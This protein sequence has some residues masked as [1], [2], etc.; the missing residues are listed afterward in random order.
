MDVQ[1]NFTSDFSKLFEGLTKIADGLKSIRDQSQT[2]NK[3][4]QASAQTA[5]I[6]QQ[7]V[8]A[9]YQAT[10]DVL[11]EFANAASQTT[12]VD[13]QIAAAQELEKSFDDAADSA[14]KLGDTQKKAG[15]DAKASAGAAA[16]AQGAA[17]IKLNEAK[18][19]ALEMVSALKGVTEEQ[20]LQL[21]EWIETSQSVDEVA[22]VI[23][24]MSDFLGKTTE[25]TKTLKQEIREAEK[26]AIDISREFGELSP[27]ALEAQAK[28]G[29]LK[30][31]FNDFRERF[32]SFSPDKKF[33]A[34]IGIASSI[35]GAFTAAQ[36]ALGLFGAESENVARSIQKVQSSL[37][38]LQGLQA[39][40]GGFQDSLKNVIALI[41]N[42]TGVTKTATAATAASTAANTTATGAAVAQTGAVNGLS[43]AWARLTAFLLANPFV[44]A[45][46]A[47][48]AITVAMIAFSNETEEAKVQVQDLSDA[49]LQLREDQGKVVNTRAEILTI[50]EKLI[51]QQQGDAK[52]AEEAIKRAQSLRKIQTDALIEQKFLREQ[53][54][55]DLEQQFQAQVSQGNLTEVQIEE[56]RVQLEKTVSQ[57]NRDIESYSSEVEKIIA[58]RE[59][60][61]LEIVQEFTERQSEEAKKRAEE[62]SRQLKLL[63][64]E[65]EALNKKLKDS[66]NTA[67]IE[68]TTDPRLRLQ[69]E[70]EAALASIQILQDEI[71]K[72]QKLLTGNGELTADQEKYFASL[73][74][75][76]NQN[77]AEGIAK[78]E[79]EIL[80]IKLDALE[81]GR[82]REIAEFDLSAKERIE[83]MRKLGVDEIAIQTIINNQRIELEKKLREELLKSQEETAIL[84]A[85]LTPALTGENEV[86]RE[87]RVQLQIIEIKKEF[88][89]KRLADLSELNVAESDSQVLA[90]RKLIQD[91][92]KET[93]SILDKNKNKQFDLLDLL[94]INFDSDEAKQK[95]KQ[96]INDTF[97]L[98][99]EG[100]Q[101][102][103]DSQ[104]QLLEADKAANDAYIQ[105]LDDRID[106]TQ[107]ALDQEYQLQA[108]GLANNVDLKKKE[109]AQLQAEKQKALEKDKA[110]A[111]EQA[112]LQ[113]QQAVIDSLSQASSMAVTIANVFKAESGK[114]IVGVIAAA[115]AALG[116]VGLF[117]SLKA[118]FNDASKQQ[119]EQGGTLD[120]NGS[121]STGGTVKGK[122][123]SQ[124]GGHRIEGTNIWVEHDEEIIK[125]RSANKYRK[126][127]KA[128]NNEKFEE[129][130][131]KDVEPIIRHIDLSPLLEGTNVVINKEEKDNIVN[132]KIEY[133]NY[134]TNA[135]QAIDNTDVVASVNLLQKEMAEFKTYYKERPRV[136]PTPEGYMEEKPGQIRFVKVR[137]DN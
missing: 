65:L 4:L 63:E 126:T 59:L 99:G 97:S 52:T 30:E 16:A 55:I 21:K 135:I 39:F 72:K 61:E 111:K 115:G 51:Q 109:L 113:Q 42:F 106:A 130:T 14:K 50:N 85:Q 67:D 24:G 123:H 11:G 96:A 15:D 103:F 121:A 56:K 69:K 76:V 110:I 44:A 91:L 35:A 38:L 129:L 18:T 79:G 84:T 23:D 122:M 75:Q 22:G 127:L 112:E 114:G 12:G 124:G 37:A 104:N 132:K 32:D 90:L 20:K 120:I 8:E 117:L 78:I 118:K 80:K 28:V 64:S 43:A 73:R 108:K 86:E 1:L 3:E 13:D 81:R 25:A 92:E 98:I 136:T 133:N 83:K 26:A 36:G 68:S 105:N 89:L 33:Q 53:A 77:Y 82:V 94:G 10:I 62:R 49:Y 88:A 29:A 58:E 40:F 107:A 116:L 60:S 102:F 2:T 131:L 74:L 70:Q 137:K 101:L 119:F 46:A 48:A 7:E 57:L 134:Q 45:A 34:F 41:N 95:F 125:R 71:Q 31:E 19:K 66:A 54:K 93:G 27:Q 17:N 100:L 87:R 9:A 47:I 128:I 6:S 5:V